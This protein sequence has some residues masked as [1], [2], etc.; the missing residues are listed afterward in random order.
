MG[1]NFK[2]GRDKLSKLT[3]LLHLIKPDPE[4]KYN[5]ADFNMNTDILES[6]IKNL[7]DK[8]TSQDNLLATKSALESESKRAKES[9]G[10][11]LSALE[12]EITRATNAEN[13]LDSNKVDK[14]SGKGLSTNDYT[15]SEKE[16][17]AGIASG[18]QVNIQSDWN[19]TDTSSD[20]YIKN[21][22]SVYSK[23][24]I[25]NKFSAL[26]TNI[27]WKESVATYDDIAT[28]YP[29]PQDGW[30]VNVKDTDYTY[31]YNG[32]SW[33]SISA[34]AIPKAT[35]SVDG[36]LSKEDHTKYEDTNSKKHTHSNKSIVDKITQT[37]LDNWNAAY[38]HISDTVKHI[39][40][41]ERTNWNSAKTHADS[42]HARSDATKVENSTTNG[43]IL[44]NGKETN[45]YTHPSGT[46]PHGTTKSDVGL[47]NVPNVTTN[48]Q[49]PTFT[50]TTS[51]TKLSNG[52]KLSVAFGKI[53][54]AITDLID[55]IGDSVKHITSSERTLWNTVSNKVDK[56]SG[57]GLSTNDLTSTLKSNYD[58][59][60]THSQSAHAP[61][62]AQANVIETVKVNG[63]ALTPS[64]KAV[65]VTIPT[66]VSQLTNDSGFKTTDNNTWKAN[67]ATSE[68]YVASG[69]NQTNKVWKTD[70]NG[71]PAWRNDANTT[72]SDATQSVHGLMTAADKKKLDG[73]SSGA[74]A[75]SLPL[76]TSSVRG[77]A[78]VGYTAN[79][80]NYPV[81]LSDEQMYVNVPWTDTNTTYGAAGSGLGLMKSGGDLTIS[82]GVA[83]V[84][85]NSHNHVIS[86]IDGLQT[87]LDGKSSSSHAH[88]D[89]YYTESEI[90]T[91]LNGKANS[92]HSHSYLPLSGGT[93]TGSVNSSKATNTY[94]DGNQGQTIINST[95]GAGAYTM[96][97]KLNS[98][99]G[100]FTDGVYQGKRLLQYTAKTTVDAGTN[101]VTKSVTL[102]D[103]SGN[104]QFSGTVT[105]PTFNGNASTATKLGTTT[106]GSATQPI[107]LNGGVPT[108]CTYTLGKSVPSNAVFTD[109]KYTHP[110]TAGNKHIPSGGSS[111]QIL[112]WSANGTAMWADASS[113]SG[114]IYSDSEPTNA[115]ENTTWIN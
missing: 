23:N 63:T 16:K 59:A 44:I 91:K 83:Q 85:D 69:A 36:L 68:G 76:A 25:D 101:S 60:Y 96:L 56:V 47:G 77:G 43:N 72:Y 113:G 98:T 81:Q 35:N 11:L 55:H 88:D 3:N 39:T 57:K 29:N 38:T 21:K 50:E 87:A 41:T 99:N 24:E 27:D 95:A 74:N 112:K 6:A 14:I 66:K 106:K 30:T 4:E 64:S 115:T 103:E 67:S 15:T 51:L 42:A 110:T 46:N 80:K 107:Y 79:G 100:Y 49:T 86:N 32:T 65:N 13:S 71:V 82:N 33:V 111:G 20:A 8:N 26:E 90:N 93:L 62:N 12:T 10:Q 108:P 1:K 2:E 58:N 97:D 102:L 28:T 19:I 52:E 109:T 34:N 73:I 9:E 94:L 45:V 92:S 40:S 54:K 104:T 31:R 18:A 89:R 37:L 7:Q 105:A 17:L 70:A 53:S 114:I 22:P 61:S 5:V 75:Y 78:K 84:N 48:D